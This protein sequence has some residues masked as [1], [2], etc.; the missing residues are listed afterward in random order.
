[1]SFTSDT[2][3]VDMML[4]EKTDAFWDNENFLLVS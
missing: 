1:M 3:K 2:K 4:N